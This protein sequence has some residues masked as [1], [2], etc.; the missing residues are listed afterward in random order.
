MI[1]NMNDLNSI[2]LFFDHIKIKEENIIINLR[3][4][5]ER[6]KEIDLNIGGEIKDE[7]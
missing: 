5:L 4:E 1:K 7:I 3:K 6:I 2:S